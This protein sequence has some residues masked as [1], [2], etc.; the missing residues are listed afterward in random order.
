[1]RI[2]SIT[3]IVLLVFHL[4]SITVIVLLVFHLENYVRKKIR[5]HKI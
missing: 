1:M 2:V 4:V 3:V 5:E